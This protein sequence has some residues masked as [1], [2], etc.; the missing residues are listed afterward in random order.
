M[1]LGHSQLCLLAIYFYKNSLKDVNPFKIVQQCVVFHFSDFDERLTALER[2]GNQN[3]NMS[4]FHLKYKKSQITKLTLNEP[5][6]IITR[7]SF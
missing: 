3:G 4:S 6:A 7:S 2:Y 1:T 5:T